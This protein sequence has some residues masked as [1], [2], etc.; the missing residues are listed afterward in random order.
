ML[1]IKE[2]VKSFEDACKVLNR[3][4]ILPDFS[5]IPEKD[6]KPLIAHYKLIVICE[7][8]NE[9]WTPDWN[10]DKWDK[11]YPWFY[12]EGS[13]SSGRFSF[14]DS[15]NRH[16]GSYCGSRLCFKSEDLAD[17]AGTQFEELYKEYFIID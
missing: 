8:L 7:A 10:N 3:E 1:T 12:M 5:M 11:F 17:Y 16:S 6:R 15:G 9:G 2:R 14:D 13:S 4:T